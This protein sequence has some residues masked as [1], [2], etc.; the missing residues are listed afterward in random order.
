MSTA[1]PCTVSAAQSA[2]RCTVAG[3]AAEPRAHHCSCICWNMRRAGPEGS[4]WGDSST[5]KR[6]SLPSAERV[7]LPSTTGDLR[8]SAWA[9]LGPTVYTLTSVPPVVLNSSMM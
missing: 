5:G 6:S 2:A 3:M 9:Y 1:L 8:A 4:T 7:T